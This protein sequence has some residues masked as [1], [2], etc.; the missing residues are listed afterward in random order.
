MVGFIACH[1]PLSPVH[2]HLLN[3]FVSHVD[4]SHADRLFTSWWR[5]MVCFSIYART[6]GVNTTISTVVLP[7]KLTSSSGGFCFFLRLSQV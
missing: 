6:D 7:L 1:V 2:A 3:G 5:E 4:L